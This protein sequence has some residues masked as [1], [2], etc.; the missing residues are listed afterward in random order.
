MHFPDCHLKD[1]VRVV[2][3]GSIETSELCFEVSTLCSTFESKPFWYRCKNQMLKMFRS[4]K[5]TSEEQTNPAEVHPH[6]KYSGL[7]AEYLAIPCFVFFRVAASSLSWLNTRVLRT[8]CAQI[9]LTVVENTGQAM[10]VSFLSKS[11]KIVLFGWMNGRK[12]KKKFL[13]QRCRK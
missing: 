13:K 8:R 6:Q 1:T 12:I 2:S 5:E 11:V 10:R 7:Q 4:P 9:P 3:N